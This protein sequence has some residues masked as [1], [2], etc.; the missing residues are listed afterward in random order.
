MRWF[1]LFRA[2]REWERAK[3]CCRSW[4]WKRKEWTFFFFFENGLTVLELA[5]F[6]PAYSRL[7]LPRG[8]DCGPVAVDFFCRRKREVGFRSP[9]WLAHYFDQKNLIS[10][11][12]KIDG[13]VDVQKFLI[14]VFFSSFFFQNVTVNEVVLLI[15]MEL[16][17]FFH[18]SSSLF[19]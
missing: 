11:L 13:K 12:N 5:V 17:G 3:A 10:P 1:T 6:L 15:Y 4:K 9:R 18:T 2:I 8:R 19:I 16:S 7:G 14:Y